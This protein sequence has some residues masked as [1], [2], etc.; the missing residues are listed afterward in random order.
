MQV[1]IPLKNN[2]TLALVDTNVYEFLEKN[3]PHI[4]SNLRAHEQGYAFY[5]KWNKGVLT[6]VYLHKLIADNFIPEDPE[7]KLVYFMNGNKLDCRLSNLR[8]INN[9]EKTRLQS[10][11]NKT[12]YKGVAV[13]GSKFLAQIYYDNK[14][15][16]LGTD[17]E[18]A[19]DAAMAYNKKAAE[20]FGEEFATNR[21]NK[22]K[23]TYAHNIPHY[24]EKGVRKFT[25]DEGRKIR[26][27]PHQKAEGKY[28]SGFKLCVGRLETH[29][30][31][32]K[33]Y[34]V[35]YLS[36]NDVFTMYFTKRQYQEVLKV[37]SQ[38]N[39]K[40]PDY[41]R[42]FNKAQLQKTR[43]RWLKRA[44]EGL[45]SEDFVTFKKEINYN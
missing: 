31:R 25:L 4:V 17:F 39:R 13:S 32:Q 35:D 20:L 29:R 10:Y 19:E 15:H 18:T 33:V 3:Y 5:Q 26:K 28:V 41:I 9:S 44:E 42:Y 38:Y 27:M 1:Q 21:V 30:G 11:Y 8:R 43:E 7:R 6:T 12:G 16:I 22:A 23:S 36:D 24:L 45:S 34:R 14:V 37:R 2:N 40:L